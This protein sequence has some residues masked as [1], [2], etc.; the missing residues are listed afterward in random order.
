MAVHDSILSCSRASRV[1][2]LTLESG[3]EGAR[4]GG[5]GRAG[6]TVGGRGRRQERLILEK[7]W[8]RWAW[9]SKEELKYSCFYEA[10]EVTW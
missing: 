4:G 2:R 7:T 9:V 10:V 5:R 6:K 1:T 3:R 8:E